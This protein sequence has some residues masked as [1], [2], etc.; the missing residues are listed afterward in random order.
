VVAA[1]SPITFAA[2]TVAFDQSAN[3]TT[4]DTRYARLGAANAF[5]ADGQTI[6]T[7]SPAVTVGQMIS[8][9]QSSNTSNRFGVNGFG[10]TTI[11]TSTVFGANAALSVGAG[12]ASNQGIVVRGA[13]SQ[14]ANLQEWQNSAGSVIARVSSNGPLFAVSFRTNGNGITSQDEAN[15]GN[16][17][18]KKATSLPGTP[19]AT[20]YAK[21]Y[22]R[23]GTVS[24]TLKL[25]VRAGT[26]GAETTILD[27]I[28]QT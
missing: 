4:N 21:L 20:G 6:L 28:P 1:T 16:I 13:A 18:V 8:V 17:Q 9:G 26:A 19:G 12:A 22:F 25:C 24:G 2:G 27:N 11:R 10:I 5:T 14:T 7:A 23:D 3:N 15:G